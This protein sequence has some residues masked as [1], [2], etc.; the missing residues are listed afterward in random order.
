MIAGALLKGIGFAT[1]AVGLGVT[2]LSDWVN[3][4]K[5]KE[6]VKLEV[7]EALANRNEN[8]EESN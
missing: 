2:V 5:M 6:Q 3:E 8:D 7:N 4:Q 1:S